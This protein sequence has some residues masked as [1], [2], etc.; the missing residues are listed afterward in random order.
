MR[1]RTQNAYRGISVVELLFAMAFF[2]ACLL[3]LM[4]AISAN[5]ELGKTLVYPAVVTGLVGGVAWFAKVSVDSAKRRAKLAILELLSD[6]RARSHAEVREVASFFQYGRFQIDA[7]SDLVSE[8][9]VLLKDGRYTVPTDRRIV[10]VG[11][12]GA[13]KV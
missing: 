13:K 6:E 5:P 3:L 8:G 11:D 2:A 10:L 4:F 7:L 9:K 1:I 12:V